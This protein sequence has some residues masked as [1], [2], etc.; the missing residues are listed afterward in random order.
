MN[1][2]LKNWPIVVVLILTMGIMLYTSIKEYSSTEAKQSFGK[3]YVLN[4]KW[5]VTVDE[6]TKK[7]MKLPCKLDGD[8]VVFVHEFV[9][10]YQGLALSLEVGN[11]TANVFVDDIPVYGMGS[12]STESRPEKENGEETE[13]K[14]QEVNTDTETENNA[15]Q[16]I[17]VSFPDQVTSGEIRVELTKVNASQGV[18]LRKATVAK[19][20]VAIIHGIQNSLV[21]IICAIVIF[22]LSV[23]ILLL[24]LVQFAAKRDVRKGFFLG[25]MGIATTVFCVMSMDVLFLIAGNQKMFLGLKLTGYIAIIPLMALFYRRTFQSYFPVLMRVTLYGSVVGILVAALMEA[26][27]LFVNVEYFEA[28][29]SIIFLLECFLILCMIFQYPKKVQ[30]D[31][32][33]PDVVGMVCLFLSGIMTYLKWSGEYGD[34]TDSLQVILMM[35]FFLIMTIQQLHHVVNLHQLEV[36]ERETF[37]LEQNEKLAEAKNEADIAN[38]AKGRFLSNMSHEIRTPINAVLGMDEMILRESKDPAIRGYAMD[39]FTSGQMLL[40]LINDILDFSKIEAGKLEIVPVEYDLSS[41][42]NDLSNMVQVR[43]SAKDIHFEVKVQEDLASRLY[44]D[45]VRIRQVLTNILTNAAKYTNE[46]SVWFR[47]EGHRQGEKQILHFE[48]ED[49]GIGIKEEDLPKLFEN[50]TRIEEKRNRNIEGTGLGMNITLELLKLMGTE[51]TVKSV[52]GKGSIF[53]FDLE[54]DIMDETPIGN[55]EQRVKQAAQDYSYSESFIAPDAKVLVVDD[56][57]TNRRVFLSLLKGTLMQIEEASGGEEAVRMAA[58]NYYDIIFMDH[59]MPGMDGVEAM[60]AIRQMEDSPCRN[61]KIY[62]LTANAVIGAKESYLKEGFDGFVSKPIV[63]RKL[64]GAILE[65]LDPEKVQEAPQREEEANQQSEEMPEYPFVDGIDWD[66]AW[67]HLMSD[68]LIRTTLKDFYAMLPVHGKKL[69]EYYEML[70][71]EEALNQYRILVHAMKGLANMLGIFPLGGMAKV[72]EFAARD[73]DI[74]II[75]GLHR[76]FLNE[77]YSYKEKLRGVMGLGEEE[78]QEADKPPYDVQKVKAYFAMLR[79]AM[80]EM[81]VDKADEIVENLSEYGYSN[82]LM[83]KM[84]ELRQA[85]TGLDEEGTNA[86]LDAMLLLL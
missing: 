30:T 83:K 67:M 47:V 17:V 36:K 71:K 16:R 14:E 59:M 85:V 11:A 63:S 39:I 43:T 10:E 33:W 44:G 37:L 19:R 57:S 49:T 75:E 1:K 23:V 4:D 74:K 82:E 34:W 48:V 78:T 77:W 52:Y 62:V 32:I 69:E 81:D 6:S 45:D 54:Q 38:E 7:D 56:N 42:I 31:R 8:T 46:G 26:G 61:T 24:D 21:P 65:A 29:I 76:I 66:V 35:V 25:L 80:E 2:K 86:I 79:Q 64:E 18:T 12:K 20:D 13:V 27:S 41:V 73:K 40:S 84:E 51:L 5:N 9:E 60:K 58:K 72:L 53:G 50:F 70:P 68:E 55:F 15:Q 3:E 22:M 28:T